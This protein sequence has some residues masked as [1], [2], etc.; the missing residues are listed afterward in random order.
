MAL[1]AAVGKKQQA[2]PIEEAQPLKRKREIPFKKFY[3]LDL[4]TLSVENTEK[5]IQTIQENLK[6]LASL[7]K[8]KLK[9]CFDEQGKITSEP[10]GS[11]SRMIRGPLDNLVGYVYPSQ[12]FTT[13]EDIENLLIFSKFID[14]NSNILLQF[15]NKKGPELLASLYQ[16]IDGL[17][18][19][20]DD[21]YLIDSK[22]SEKA[23]TEECITILK[24]MRDRIRATL[25]NYR[26][27]LQIT[28]LVV[29]KLGA[30][31]IDARDNK[32]EDLIEI[33]SCLIGYIDYIV[34]SQHFPSLDAI[35]RLSQEV[36]SRSVLP[37]D[38]TLF[39]TCLLWQTKTI[40]L[41]EPQN[42]E[43]GVKEL[44]PLLNE[45]NK[46]CESLLKSREN[47]RSLGED[48]I[49]V[50]DRDMLRLRFP[51]F[52]KIVKEK[53]VKNNAEKK[54]D[55]ILLRICLSILK[56][57][58]GGLAVSTFSPLSAGVGTKIIGSGVDDICQMLLDQK[59][60]SLEDLPTVKAALIEFKKQASDPEVG[61]KKLL[62]VCDRNTNNGKEFL[63]DIEKT[64]ATLKSELQ[65]VISRRNKTDQP[66]TNT[67]NPT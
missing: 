16:A 42:L 46:E 3:S 40:E 41:F 43:S 22:K 60:I 57:A 67:T 28:R 14:S 24:T 15:N 52:H 30:A 62:E 6:V 21:Q 4:S 53:E 17:E 50:F 7:N 27:P 38:H 2:S 29:A 5:L 12:L 39:L 51:L 59:S 10:A 13:N 18:Q 9:L 47:Y 63:D 44:E 19:L 48:V 1:P 37:T 55:D 8:D 35:S 32:K 31:K 56:I 20:R 61:L 49:K 45:A 23:V 34:N 66:P 64:R 54:S 58:G 36:L 11:W 26:E 65:E 25:H 33:S